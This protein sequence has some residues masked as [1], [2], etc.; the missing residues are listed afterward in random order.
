MGHESKPSPWW[1]D[2]S[3]TSPGVLIEISDSDED[4][5]GEEAQYHETL[6]LLKQPANHPTILQFDND[7]EWRPIQIGRKT[8]WQ[9]HVYDRQ[10]KKNWR[11]AQKQEIEL[12]PIQEDVEK[13]AL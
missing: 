4:D 11:Q 6:N 13:E 1:L 10:P 5:D 3:T 2:F 8:N 7:D 9:Y 12:L